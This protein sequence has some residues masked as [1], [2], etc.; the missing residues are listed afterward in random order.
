L[1]I[2]AA[3]EGAVHSHS[4]QGIAEGI[5]ADEL[6]HVAV[7]A[8]TTLGFPRAIAALTWIEDVTDGRERS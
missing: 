7:L 3:S 4:R 6:K 2:G 1:A 8:A 5:S